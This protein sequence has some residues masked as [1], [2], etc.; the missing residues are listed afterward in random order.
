M[1]LN[2]SKC[3]A[4]SDISIND[5]NIKTDT[6]KYL[7]VIENFN[8]NAIDMNLEIIENEI[9]RRFNLVLKSKLSSKNMVTAINEYAISVINFFIGIVDLD[10][11]FCKDLDK[12][13]RLIMIKYK[14]H[15]IDSSIERLYLPRWQNGRGVKSILNHVETISYNFSNYI[16]ENNTTRKKIIKIGLE[17]SS[18]SKIL[19]KKKSIMERYRLIENEINKSTINDIQKNQLIESLKNK[20]LHGT[21]FKKL[22][23]MNLSHTN[24][25]EWLLYGNQKPSSEA[26]GFLMQDR[27]L[28]SFYNS[29]KCKF[30]KKANV[31]I[32][33]LA[34]RCR[35]LLHSSYIRRHNEVVKCIHLRIM[36]KFLITTRKKLKGH[37]IEKVVKNDNAEIISEIPIK[38]DSFITNNKPDLIVFDNKMN[39]IYLIEIG[40]TS[41]DN[42]KKYEVEK[43]QKYRLLAKEMEQMYSRKVIISPYVITWDG[44]TTNYN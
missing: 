23:E 9:L 33:H 43:F 13:I 31:S 21:F 44:V 4:N 16:N 5:Q 36:K 42:L 11:K 20:S 18:D 26:Y 25:N 6:Y 40:I 27:Y 2:I 15:F 19:Y 12:K 38:T 29:G 37:K 35:L 30:C 7:G 34:T 8:K 10:E 39:I 41:L 17:S 32:D 1:Y 14:F 22:L 24:C 28:S 3:G